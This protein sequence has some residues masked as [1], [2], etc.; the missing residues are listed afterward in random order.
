MKAAHQHLNRPPVFWETWHFATILLAAFLVSLLFAGHT[1]EYPWFYDDYNQVRLF[2]TAELLQS[3][4]GRWDPSG[5]E[6]VS[7]RPLVSVINHIRCLLFGENMVLHRLFQLFV[8]ALFISLIGYALLLTGLRKPF[9]IGGACFAII[10]KSNGLNIAWPT[11]A[12][13]AISGIPLALACVLAAN[14][15][16]TLTTRSKVF[17]FFLA[18]I[19]IFTREHNIA[20]FPVVVLLGIASRKNEFILLMARGMFSIKNITK[21]FMVAVDFLIPL[22]SSMLIYFYLRKLFVPDSIPGMNIDGMLSHIKMTINPMGFMVSKSIIISWLIFVFSILAISIIQSRYSR[23]FLLGILGWITC[24]I[25]GCTIGLVVE[26]SDL[27]LIP[28]AIFSFGLAM[29][30]QQIFSMGQKHYVKVLILSGVVFFSSITWSES[31]ASLLGAH[32]QSYQAVISAAMFIYGDYASRARTPP[33]RK[34]AAIAYLHAYG[35]D[36]AEDFN[37]KKESLRE[38]ATKNGSTPP[39]NGALFMPRNFLGFM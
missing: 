4:H 18:S 14:T 28:G 34:K 3:M 26:R 11:V 21:I 16:G 22:I 13:H 29:A 35:I 32:P 39:A 23:I 17:I 5:I 1:L 25:L 30:L 27:L 7:Y 9:V 24:I 2:S 20:L 31:R 8:L 19:S 12:M 15:R 33:E 38:E 6:T 37:A 10:A 36:S